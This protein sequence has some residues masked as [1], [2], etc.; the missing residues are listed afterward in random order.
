MIRGQA[1]YG[2]DFDPGDIEL[3]DFDD[4]TRSFVAIGSTGTSDRMADIVDQ[5]GWDLDNFLKNPVGMWVHNYRELPIFQ[6]RDMDIKPKAKKMYFKPHFDDYEFADK[7]YRSYKKGFMRAFS[8]GFIPL[9]Y[10]RR[11]PEDMTD[12]EKEKAGWFGGMHFKR[13]ELLEISAVPIPANP[14]ALAG[15]KSMGIPVEWHGGADNMNLSPNKSTLNDGSTWI[16]VDDI[17]S[18][19]DL[20]IVK[21]DDIRVVNGKFLGEDVDDGIISKVAGYIFPKGFTDEQIVEWFIAKNMPEDK[22]TGYVEGGENYLELKVDEGKFE[23]K[24]P[25]SEPDEVED[26][27]EDATVQNDNVESTVDK[28][29]EKFVIIPESIEIQGDELVINA[30]LGTCRVNKEV[31]EKAGLE[32]REDELV[33]VG[34]RESLEEA[35][36]L[37]TALLAN[38]KLQEET[39]PEPELQDAQKE[40]EEEE[41]FALLIEVA[42]ELKQDKDSEIEIDA[43]MFREVFGEVLK[44]NLGGLVKSSVKKNLKYVTGDLDD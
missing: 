36:N 35:C 41:E 30:N 32:V 3:K 21:I 25:E 8:V 40:E 19:S 4:N 6:I 13:Q 15:A 5:K 29:K 27:E 2:S 44:E 22:A 34:N 24:E 14:E 42:E 20:S 33:T 16:P 26:V 18:F 12:D 11:D 17:A 7:V 9:E 23:L 28:V 37:L 43:E 31:L 39:E 1:V 10:E 38:V